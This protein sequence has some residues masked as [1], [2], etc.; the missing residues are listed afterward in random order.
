MRRTLESFEYVSSDVRELAEDRLAS[1]I[2]ELK[3]S[4]L[5]RTTP[6]LNALLKL[7]NEVLS[8]DDP[9]PQQRLINTLA[10]RKAKRY[11]A[12]RQ[13]MVDCGFDMGPAKGPEKK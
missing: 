5:G 7:L 8:S 2:K 1:L 9:D 13:R 10:K 11:L 6:E 12:N 4:F 3:H